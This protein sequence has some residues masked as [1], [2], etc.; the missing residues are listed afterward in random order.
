M[1][2]VSQ[3]PGW[4]IASDGKWYAPHLHPSVRIPEQPD[5]ETD[6]LGDHSGPSA[7]PDPEQFSDEVPAAS[8]QFPDAGPATSAPTKRSRTPLAAAAAILVVILLV[9]GAVVVFGGAKSAS[10]EVTDAVNSSLHDGTAHVTMTISGGANGTDVTGTGAGGID[11]ANN[12][13]EVHMTVA[14]G[15]RQVPVDAIYLGGVVYESIPGLGTV[16]PGK[17]W[18]SIDLSALQKAQ[19]QSPSTQGLGNDPTVM[20]QILA[21][22]GNTVVP[23]G[24]STVDGV[25]VDGYS[26]TV[27]PASVARRLKAA[28]LPSWMQQVVSGLKVH[29]LGIK[30]YIDHAGLLRSLAVKVDETTGLSGPVTF[31]ETVGFS[32]YGTALN[33]TAPPSAQ[34][35]SFQQLLQ[36]AG[37][38]GTS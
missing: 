27:N 6:H 20:L 30:V 28:N 37:A 23:L 16:A 25:P 1:S 38:R 10:A 8:E 14:S 11:F 22:Q 34:V 29:D 3:G 35:E 9:I 26:V 18:L 13:L 4:W 17:S 2:D 31:D 24:P 32:D 19:A 7:E 15:G 21:Q 12:A 36:A 33:V 5:A